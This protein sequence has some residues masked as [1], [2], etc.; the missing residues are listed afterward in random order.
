MKISKFLAEKYLYLSERAKHIKKRS[1]YCIVIGFVLSVLLFIKGRD[2]IYIRPYEIMRS[3]YGT[4]KTP[5]KLILDAE[6]LANN[7][8]FNVTVS[9]RK[10]EK[11]EADR[12]FIEKLVSLKIDMLGENEDLENVYTKLNLKKDLGDGVRANYAFEPMEI[13]EI[14]EKYDK[15]K[16]KKEKD[17]N[18]NKATNSIAT[19]S[20]IGEFK[21]YVKYQGIVD[22]NGNVKNE[23]FK[24]GEFCTGYIIVQLITDIKGQDMPYKSMKQMLPIRIISRPLSILESFKVDF[25]KT[26]EEKDRDTI[27]NDTVSLPK[28]VN[29]FRISY[30]EKLDLRFL[31]MPLLGLLFALLLEARDKENEKEREK[32]KTR[33][34]EIDFSQIITKVLLYVSS[35]MTIR[36]SFIRLAEQHI[37]MR[38]NNDVERV[39]YDELIV[40]KNKLLSGYSEV[41]AYEEMANAINM[42]IYTRFLNIII[43]SIKNGNKDL[44]NILNMEVQDALYERKQNAKKLGEEA[45]TKL[46]LPLMMILAVIMLVI[47][48]PAF[49][50]M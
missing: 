33:Y 4:Q 34:L 36:N 15:R 37:N 8:E 20:S 41:K 38:N 5:Y 16:I 17:L 28:I 30:K 18:V 32:R 40:V 13:E 6:N 23:N 12:I 45:T 10:Y 26:F 31:L 29:N 1:I 9:A 49:M 24:V 3:S 21:Y 39:A 44:K 47:M 11:E 43:Q 19:K 25:K 48:M 2:S 42:R 22:G 50:G 46:V 35:G 14:Y 7:M 27:S